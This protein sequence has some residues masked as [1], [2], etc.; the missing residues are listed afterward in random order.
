MTDIEQYA[1]EIHKPARKNFK[2]RNINSFFKNE[3]WGADLMDVSN[4]SEDN[5]SVKFILNIIDIYSRYVWSFPIRNKSGKNI[6]DCFN[7]LKELP[8]KLWVDEGKEFYNKEFKK[9]CKDNNINMYHTYSGVKSSFV[10]RFNRTLREKMFK[11]FT[12]HNTNYYIDVLDDFVNA[13]NNKIH[14]RTKIKPYDAYYKNLTPHYDVSDNVDTPKY[15]IGD[16]VR[17]SRVKKTFEKGY[18]ARWSKEIFEIV[19]IDKTSSPIMYKLN[20][21]DGEDITGKFY[22]PE[23]LKTDLKDF[24]VIEKIISKKKVNGKYKYLVKWDGY[25]DKFNTWITEEQMETIK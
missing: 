25:P 3:L 9:F 1:D 8:Q 12:Q 21:L 24:A 22:E 20:D 11:Y 14:S 23:L 4:I 15:K 2:R 13:Y 17:I 18:T 6:V 5:N 16:F 10:E 19:G 7:K